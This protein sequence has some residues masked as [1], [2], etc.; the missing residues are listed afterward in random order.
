M[1]I[2]LF[3]LSSVISKVSVGDFEHVFVRWERYRIT[4]VVLRVFDK[5]YPAN[6]YLHKLNNRN[7]KTGDSK[8]FKS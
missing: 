7:P 3:E 2:F 4:I 1:D 6:N 8:S 5:P